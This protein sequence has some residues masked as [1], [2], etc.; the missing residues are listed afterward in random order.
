LSNSTT[1]KTKRERIR[2]LILA[3]SPT[4]YI[5]DQ[6]HTSKEYVYKERGKLKAEGLLVEHRSLTLSDG[7]KDIVVVRDQPKIERYTDG[8]SISI[9]PVNSPIQD[10]DI[11]PLDTKGAMLMYNAFENG[12]SPAHVT[13]Q[14][15]IHPSTSQKEYNR[16]LAMNSRDPFDLQNKIVSGISNAPPEIQSIIDKSDGNLLTNDEILKLID[17]KNWNNAH[18]HIGK[19]VLNVA[20]DLPDRIERPKCKQCKAIHHG[21]IYD[22]NT[23]VGSFAQKM[24][25]NMFCHNCKLIIDE[26]YAQFN[27]NTQTRSF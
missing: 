8:E 15:G 16:Y 11:P 7:Q 3:S 24:L 1:P 20:V 5:V 6:V 19:A 9:D 4:K 14:Y 13:A 10:Y 12:T 25:D 17:F 18:N 2:E 22:R 21:V 23:Y 26:I 27:Q